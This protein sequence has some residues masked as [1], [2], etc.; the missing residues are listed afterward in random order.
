MNSLLA[1]LADL[2]AIKKPS[3]LVMRKVNVFFMFAAHAASFAFLTS[4][5]Y[6]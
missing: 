6:P 2:L 1:I 3:P 5:G 4:Q